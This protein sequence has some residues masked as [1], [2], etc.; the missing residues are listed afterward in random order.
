L[1]LINTQDLI[2]EVLQTVKEPSG[3]PGTIGTPHWTR[4][5]ILQRLNLQQDKISGE[6]PGL[7]QTTDT[8]LT[9]TGTNAGL[10]VPSSIGNI[11]D[12]QVNGVT[13]TRTSREAIVDQ[14]Q[15]G[16]IEDTWQNTASSL[17]MQDDVEFF[18]D[19][20]NSSGVE[21]QMLYFYPYPIS[22]GLS[23]T[24][25]GDLIL[26][27]LADNPLSFPMENVPYLS[28]AQEILIKLTA[29]WCALEDSRTELYQMLQTDIS[30]LMRT[31]RKNYLVLRTNP[32]DSMLVIR[33]SED[34]GSAP[35]Y[36][37][38]SST[39]STGT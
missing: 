37:R 10:V 28:K 13:I 12:I 11:K 22:A 39:S 35:T 15:R 21:A 32:R 16:E 17:G 29:Q 14:S 5:G 26:T 3:L 34:A 30:E 27:N 18:I 36:F 2:T 8:S 33:R 6:L 24:I 38:V 31:L 25:Q 23:I 19:I 1:A 20:D 9:T 7:F 4:A